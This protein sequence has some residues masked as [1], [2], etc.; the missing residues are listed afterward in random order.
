MNLTAWL[1]AMVGPLTARVLASL[2]LSL[3]SMGGLTAALAAMKDGIMDSAGSLP[4]AAAQLAGILGLWECIAIGLGAC[5]FVVT[6]N[7][8]AGMWKLGK[9]AT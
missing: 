9:A 7:T 6:W 1:V 3:V 2:G 5:T 8:T 4:M